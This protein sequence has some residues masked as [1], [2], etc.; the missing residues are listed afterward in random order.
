[1]DEELDSTTLLAFG[2]QFGKGLTKLQGS[3]MMCLP[4]VVRQSLASLLCRCIAQSPD[5]ATLDLESFSE[6]QVTYEGEAH[7]ILTALSD[8][9]ALT[10]LT[11]VKLSFL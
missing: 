3:F 6:E 5:L 7:G 4:G 2:T 9:M 8:N 10:K 1:M 11:S